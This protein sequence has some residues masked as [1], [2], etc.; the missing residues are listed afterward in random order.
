MHS[1]KKN[2]SIRKTEHVHWAKR[3]D[4]RQSK[5]LGQAHAFSENE[6]AGGVP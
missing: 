2:L 6:F 1:R 4:L 3:L 5:V